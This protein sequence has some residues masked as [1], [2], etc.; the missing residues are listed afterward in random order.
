MRCSIVSSFEISFIAHFPQELLKKDL[1]ER[2][3]KVNVLDAVL[4]EQLK[5]RLENEKNKK[6]RENYFR[7]LTHKIDEVRVV[8]S[9][10][11]FLEIHFKFNTFFLFIFKCNIKIEEIEKETK[12][13][14]E[15]TSSETW[16][17]DEIIMELNMELLVS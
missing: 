15:R 9:P 12:K 4:V 17:D 10:E 2:E 16:K 1:L 3:E 11:D 7:I 8:F 13:E 6:E 5:E 14:V